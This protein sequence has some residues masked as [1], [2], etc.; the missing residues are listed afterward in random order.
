MEIK[1]KRYYFYYLAAIGGFIVALLPLWVGFFLA[2]IAGRFIFAILY[3]DRRRAIGNLKSAFPEK[4]DAEIRRITKGVFT[5]LCKS[6]V[7]IA[8]TYKLNRVNIDRWV[9]SEGFEKVDRAL[10]KGKGV[11]I[12]AS[13]FGNWELMA[14]YYAIKGY[15]CN[16]I[17][18]RIY[19]D[20]YDR[21][22]NKVRSSWGI[23]VIFRDGSLKK[24]LKKLKQNEAMGILADQD[25]D[26]VD[27]IFVDFFG[28][29][30]YT[31]RGPVALALA[32]GA[33][34]I[35]SFIIRQ[36]QG[37]KLIVSDPIELVKKN[38]R[39]ETIRYNTQKWT[40]V[41]EEYIRKYPEQ[42]VW[43]HRRW[44]TKPA[45]KKEQAA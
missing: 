6:G 25:M 18:R 19:F 7:E 9:S 15:P 21:F 32:S 38:D 12:L 10:S 23:N 24:I 34:L 4:T 5:N 2:N 44:K 26:S 29:P 35:P 28:K 16:T 17:A 13:H 8:N 11:I 14:L 40:R 27:G 36:K 22:I 1:T 33:P 45:G 39:E 31:P 42:W 20:R 30:A 43:M 3:K 37:H 41:F